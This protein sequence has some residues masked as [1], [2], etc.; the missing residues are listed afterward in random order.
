MTVVGVLGRTPGSPRA[1]TATSWAGLGRSWTAP[2]M[3]T[4]QVRV[5]G[6]DTTRWPLTRGSPA[7][8]PQ[9]LVAVRC[10]SVNSCG[11][12]CG[13]RVCRARLPRLAGGVACRQRQG[14]KPVR[15]TASHIFE[16]APHGITSVIRW[17][18]KTGLQDPTDRPWI[19]DRVRWICA[20]PRFVAGSAR[21]GRQLRVEPPGVAV[22][23]QR[24]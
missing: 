18:R 3:P 6:P 13:I 21:T 10:F 8:E 16:G 15:L 20:H 1:I 5:T 2:D 24:R 22:V 23:D 12:C 19:N 7:R 14:R 9:T 11:W 17:G 4:G